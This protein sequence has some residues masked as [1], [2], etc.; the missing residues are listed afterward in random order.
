[1]SLCPE[2]DKRNSMTDEEFWNHVFPQPEFF[3]WDDDPPDPDQISVPCTVCH[4]CGPCGYD[5]EGRPMIHTEPGED[6]PS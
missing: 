4:S 2:F 1:M 5:N 3:E 6:S